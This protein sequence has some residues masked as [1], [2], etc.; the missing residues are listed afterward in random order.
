MVQEILNTIMAWLTGFWQFINITITEAIKL[1]YS[2]DALTPL[3]ILALFGLAV[4]VVYLGLNF[5]RSFFQK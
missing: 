1:F 2:N 4:G 3:G 5:V